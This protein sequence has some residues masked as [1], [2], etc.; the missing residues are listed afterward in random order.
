MTDVISIW[1]SAGN[2]QAA[3]EQSTVRASATLNGFRVE[4]LNM[5][6]QNLFNYQ[7]IYGNATGQFKHL[8]DLYEE[9]RLLGITFE[10]KQAQTYG[11]Y[12]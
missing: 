5:N 7:D 2:F 3:F 1:V 12:A 6:Q 9:Y 8:A 10:W 11:V 4:V